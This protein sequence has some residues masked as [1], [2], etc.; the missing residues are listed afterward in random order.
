[1]EDEI[2]RLRENH[3]F[4]EQVLDRAKEYFSEA[5]SKN[6]LKG[7]SKEELLYA[8]LY[9]AFRMLQIPLKLSNIARIS[10]LKPSRL[11]WLQCTG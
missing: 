4:E 3:L 9:L 11:E 5:A 7:L 2:S 6:I 8:S 10:N 1:M